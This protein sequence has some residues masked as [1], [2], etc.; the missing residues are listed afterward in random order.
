MKKKTEVT[1]RSS[2]SEM[3]P[4]AFAVH[5]GVPVW[6]PCHARSSSGTLQWMSTTPMMSG[7]RSRAIVAEMMGMSVVKVSL[8]V[9]S[10]CIVVCVVVS[11]PPVGLLFRMRI[12]DIRGS[13]DFYLFRA[14]VGIIREI[15]LHLHEKR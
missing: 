5:N 2:S 8:L 10:C 1:V 7:R 6:Q 15:C 13:D 4:M 3:L 12:A 9:L 14:N 11:L